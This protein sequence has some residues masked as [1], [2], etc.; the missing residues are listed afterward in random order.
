MKIRMDFVTNSSSSSFII[1]NKSNTEKTIVDLFKENIWLC[2]DKDIEEVLASA[3]QL[4]INFIPNETKEIECE[5]HYENLVETLIHNNLCEKDNILNMMSIFS[6]IGIST[7]LEY[8]E[9]LKNVKEESESFKW[10]FGES[11]H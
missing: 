1:T 2:E 4:N 11:H 9:K 5:D 3:K 7:P 6:Q 10:K 8:M